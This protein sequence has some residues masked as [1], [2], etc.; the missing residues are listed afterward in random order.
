MQE[1]GSPGRRLSLGAVA[2][3]AA[4]FATGAGGPPASEG[5]RGVWT[6]ERSTWRVEKGGTA[7][8]VQ[9]SLRRVTGGRGSWDS[10]HPVPLTELEGLTTA[11][12]D[13][14]SAD[15][16]FA[17]KRDAA[18]F[19]LEGASRRD[20]EPGTLPLPPAGPTLPTCEAAGMGT[21]TTR[22]P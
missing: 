3:I 18:T 9:L 7:T 5:I 8:L 4:L 20:R 14:A 19:S 10:S 21:S 13:A 2:L 6:A 16:R 1:P 11:L 22:R 12:M 17:W 15:I